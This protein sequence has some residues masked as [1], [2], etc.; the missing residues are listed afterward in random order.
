MTPMTDT[1]PR[2]T[3]STNR[4]A[5]L[6][7]RLEQGTRALMET[8]ST[9]TEAQWRMPLPGD[10]RPIGVVVHHVAS[11][12]P[13][14]IQLAQTVAAG[15]PV[16]G[17]TLDDIHTMNAKH[18]REHAEVAK[19]EAVALL[20]ANGSAAANAIRALSDEQLAQAAPVSLYANAP[21]TCQFVLEDHAVRHSYHHLARIR[22]AIGLL[23]VFILA[24]LGLPNAVQAEEHEHAGAK[25]AALTETVREATRQ[26]RDLQRALDAGYVQFLGC[27]S[28]PQEGAMGVH[29]VK[30][31]LLDGEVDATQPEALIYEFTGNVARLVGV[32]FIAP[33]PAWDPTHDGPPVLDGQV[34]QFNGSPNRYRIPAFYELHVWAWRENPN[35][36]F[37]DWNTRVTCDG[38][39]RQ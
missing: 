36:T 1:L 20:A 13:I 9:L 34:F 14:E 22:A 2:A 27:V 38:M 11:V 29:F 25:S 23:A 4:A 21:V 30:G 37:V 12:Y 10:G 32:E 5:Q 18:A 19:A 26:Y 28:G 7:E 6:A 17:V 3:T 33:A 35:G 24:W 15:Q 39:T 8:A 16:A 31:S